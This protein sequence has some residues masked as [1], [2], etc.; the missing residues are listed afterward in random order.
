M[1][2]DEPF[3]ALVIVGGWNR[4]IFTPDWIQRY[5]LPE[6]QVEM[7]I[8]FPQGFNAQFVSPQIS[9]KKVRILLQG[10]RLNFSPVKNEDEN[11]DRIQELALQLAGHLPHTPVSGYG[12][13]FLFTED[14]ISENLINVI[15]PSDSEEIEKFFSTPLIGEEYTRR[16]ALNG[17]TFNFTV[18]LEGEEVTLSCNFHFDIQDLVEFKKKISETPILTL[19]QEAAKFI[20]E[21]YSLELK[22]EAE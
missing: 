13:N 3:D 19:K 9:S 11:F 7:K 15:R 1:K 5:L 14:H 6:E 8:Q 17:R 16:L 20:A 21:T 12:V 18:G 4:Y 10:N 22:G 2:F